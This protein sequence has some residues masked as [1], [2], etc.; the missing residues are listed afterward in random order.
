MD[1]ATAS[2]GGLESTTMDFAAMESESA[3]TTHA[4]A[5]EAAATSSV[6]TGAEADFTGGRLDRDTRDAEGRRGGNCNNDFVG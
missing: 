6:R 1:F 4:G 2:S 5:V 3:A